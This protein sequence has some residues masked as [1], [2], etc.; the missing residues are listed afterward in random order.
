M[1]TELKYKNFLE[2]GHHLPEPQ[3]DNSTNIVKTQD[4]LSPVGQKM[5]HNEFNYWSKIH[6]IA[7]IATR[8]EY[9]TNI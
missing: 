4:F 6:E 8:N 2:I 7:I 5:N 1:N 3:P 9:R